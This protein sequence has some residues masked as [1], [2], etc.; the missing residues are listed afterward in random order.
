M[1]KMLDTTGNVD[2][3][4]C[5]PIEFPILGL[6]KAHIIGKKKGGEIRLKGHVRDRCIR[7]VIV[8]DP[9]DKTG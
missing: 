8:S 9:M 2:D 3:H 7:L 1:K 4:S 6:T 5:G